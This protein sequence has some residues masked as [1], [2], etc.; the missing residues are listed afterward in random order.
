MNGSVKLRGKTWRYRFRSPQI[1]PATG[2]HLWITKGGF[3]LKT[4]AE[5]AMRDPL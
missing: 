5:A 1:N 2:R 4:E 3:R